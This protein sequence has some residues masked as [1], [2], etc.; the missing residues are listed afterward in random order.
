MAPRLQHFG[1]NDGGTMEDFDDQHLSTPPADAGTRGLIHRIMQGAQILLRDELAL[2]KFELIRT[3]ERTA[4]GIAALTLGGVL[5]LIS[6][7]LLCMTVVVALQPLVPALWL[8]MLLMSAIYFCIGSLLVGICVAW[9]SKKAMTLPKTKT[10]AQQTFA[11]IK[12]EVQ[13]A[14]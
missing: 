10:Q 14:R 9:L 11:T 8:R 1:K 4:A 5:A 7:S 13:H 2:A 12:A 6:L 3:G